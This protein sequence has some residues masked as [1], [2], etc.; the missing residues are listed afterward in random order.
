MPLFDDEAGLAPG[1]FAFSG[2]R[3]EDLQASEFT[4]AAVVVDTSGSVAPYR[5]AI[6]GAL[7][8]VVRACRRH[9]RADHMML[10]VVTF[11]RDLEEV[12]GFK[13]LPECSDGDYQGALNIYGATALYDA[14]YSAVTS[15]EGYARR[16]AAHGIA[17]NAAVFVITD[18]E[19]N[20]STL[21][22]G[23]VRDGLERAVTSET[24]ES[25]TSVLVG[26]CTGG[27]TLHGTLAA[28]QQRCGFDRYLP[29][30][31]ASEQ[32]LAALA[33]FIGRSVAAQSVALG[34]GAASQLL[35]F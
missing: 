2:T 20:A 15:V 4:L 8:E 33:E 34:S 16:L 22:E 19:D 21:T 32:R 1:R 18:G 7:V 29:L 9:P 24:L 28:V 25:L 6:E 27:D 3:V 10:R 12:H 30:E 5:A 13:P 35:T 31:S 23:M 17:A 26:V 14:C 11:N